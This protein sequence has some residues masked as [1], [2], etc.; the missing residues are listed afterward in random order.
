M[1]LKIY[2]IFNLIFYTSFFKKLYFYIFQ[3]IHIHLLVCYCYKEKIN[4][5]F[6]K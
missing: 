1:I 5:R 3:K 6:F 4:F 2:N